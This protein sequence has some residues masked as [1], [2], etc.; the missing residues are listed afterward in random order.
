MNSVTP[1]SNQTSLI[2]AS[3]PLL[4]QDLLDEPSSMI[5]ADPNDRFFSSVDKSS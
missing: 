1:N 5:P 2:N 3:D 4:I